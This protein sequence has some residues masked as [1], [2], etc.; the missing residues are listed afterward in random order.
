MN[1]LWFA[2]AGLA[3][4]IISGM[5]I[6]G[7]AVLIPALTILL[8]TGQREAQHINL[9]FFLPTAAIALCTHIKEGNIEKKGLLKLTL[10]GVLG[11]VPAALIAVR[12]NADWLRKGFA[13]FLLCMA[14]YELV[15]GWKKRKE[16]K[17]SSAAPPHTVNRRQ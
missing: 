12:I 10:F 13:V 6:G 1:W 7:G 4:G 14:V 15:K 8:A 16:R 2:L 9:L 17:G 11:A 3:A 5:G